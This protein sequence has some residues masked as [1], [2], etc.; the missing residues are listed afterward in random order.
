MIKYLSFILL[1][2][3][4]IAISCQKQTQGKP[5]QSMHL[6]F[7]EGD[8]TSLHPHLTAGHIRCITLGK[9]L[10]DG[11]TRINDKEEAELSGAESVEISSDNTLY[12]FTLRKTFWTDG[13]PV[14]AHQYE[15]AWK[16]AI[17]PNSPCTRSDLFYMIKNA[18]EIKKGEIPL[19][20]A[21]IRALDSKTLRIELAS[22][23]PAFLKLVSQPIFAPLQNPSEE[24]TQ[25]N[26]SFLVDRWEQ[27][28]RIILKKNPLFWNKE[29]V[30]LDQIQI[31]FISDPVTALHLYNNGSLDWIGSPSSIIPTEA[32]PAME[33]EGKVSRRLSSLVFWLHLNTK[34]PL[35][36]SP[37]IR[38][39]LSLVLDRDTISESILDDKPLY[40]PLPSSLSL[41]NQAI[42][43]D[44]NEAQRL[45][46][47]GLQELGLTQETMP[48]IHFRYFD[49]PTVKALA[50]YLQETWQ[51]E[52]G[53]QVNLEC[54]EWKTFRSAMEL[55]DFE[56]ASCY[57]RPFYPDP[58]D[59][60][61]RF[62]LSTSNFS[63]W[64]HSLYQEKILSANAT[65]DFAER[66]RWL[67]EAEEILLSEVPVIPVA[68]G[69]QIYCRK[70]NL[71]GYI[72]DHGGA[73]DFSF[74]YFEKS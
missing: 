44:G 11:L 28:A 47:Q 56:I 42:V 30:Q 21:G 52:F 43:Q 26:G 64:T 8:P 23:C 12:T 69:V 45:F 48:P 73:V 65:K 13:S 57:E 33:N 37:S 1:I 54:T 41:T 32:I 39:A 58:L 72:F 74:V 17:E 34:S 55:G 24:P 9:L 27:G 25:F 19:Q 40:T 62:S 7:Q 5:M 66:N 36:K 3:S 29:K 20:E 59:L 61:E 18:K 38:K 6:I 31:S 4:L 22:P 60:L 46:K 15:A 63:Q 49:R 35:L 10:F 51:N 2:I 53:I 67:K 68:N 50:Q 16:R 14:T 71:K 70:P